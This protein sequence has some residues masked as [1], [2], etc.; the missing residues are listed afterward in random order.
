MD[1]SW[2]ADFEIAATGM[3]NLQGT[4]RLK[5]SATMAAVMPC[6]TRYETARTGPSSTAQCSCSWMQMRSQ[7]DEQPAAKS[8]DKVGALSGDRLNADS[9]LMSQGLTD[10]NRLASS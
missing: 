1:I 10:C 6:D 4:R 5:Q 7:R 3:E 8:S 9:G 2:H